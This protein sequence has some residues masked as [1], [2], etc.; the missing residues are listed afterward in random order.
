MEKSIVWHDMKENNQDV[1]THGMWFCCRIRG[2]HDFKMVCGYEK[3][4]PDHY[5]AWAEILY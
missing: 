1:P 3:V 2:S 4:K 5:D